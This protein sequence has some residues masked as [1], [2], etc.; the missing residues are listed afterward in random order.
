M[1]TRTDTAP[2]L[3]EWLGDRPLLL[4]LWLLLAT[5]HYRR[6][7]ERLWLLGLVHAPKEA[8]VRLGLLLAQA[9]K[10]ASGLLLLRLG[11]P[12]E[13]CASLLL[14][15]WQ[16]RR[17]KE[18]CAPLLLLRLLLLRLRGSPKEAPASLLLLWLLY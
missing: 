1:L 15:C 4:W 17:A 5:A 2:W 12:E 18:A 13:S 16:C 10:E 11:A 9:A 8:R 14:L 3:P 7:E 6:P